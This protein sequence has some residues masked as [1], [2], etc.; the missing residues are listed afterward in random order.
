M[1][2]ALVVVAVMSLVVVVHATDVEVSDDVPWEQVVF[3]LALGL[4]GL[5]LA[6]EP[7]GRRLRV[8]QLPGRRVGGRNGCGCLPGLVARARLGTSGEP[9]EQ[10]H[11]V[12]PRAV[13]VLGHPIDLEAER[14]VEGD[15]VLVRR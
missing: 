10:E 7:D 14:L 4:C 11:A 8:G 9:L 13:V 12:L 3:G 2:I 1:L 5:T 15:R 6:Q